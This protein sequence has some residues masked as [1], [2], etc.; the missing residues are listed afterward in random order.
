LQHRAEH[1]SMTMASL[2]HRAPAITRP[3]PSRYLVPECITMSAP[4]CIGPL[5][6]WAWQSS[7]P[8]PSSAPALCAKSASAC[9]VADLGQ[10]VGGRLGKQQPGVG[11]MAA[12]RQAAR[13]V[14]E[15]KV[16]C[17]PKRGQIG[18]DEL[19]GRAEHGARARR[20][21]RRL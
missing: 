9:D 13:S 12:S 19:D 5:Q 11:R 2:A 1:L 3:W 4:M 6:R 15:T 21:G 16:D 10:R 17:T 14:C 20:R 8:R 18:A 7:C